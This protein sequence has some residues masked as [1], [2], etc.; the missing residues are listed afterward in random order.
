MLHSLERVRTVIRGGQPDRPPLFEL[1]RN[2]A[3]IRHFTGTELTV[4]NGADLVYRAYAPAVDATRPMVKHPQ[5]EQTLTLADGRRQEIRRWTVWTEHRRFPDSTAYEREMRGR[6]A[7]YAPAWTPADQRALDDAL[8]AMAADRARLGEV[9]CFP[10]IPGPGLMGLYGEVGLEQFAYC[11]ADCPDVAV[12][13][14][15]MNTLAA[16]RWY[17]HLPEGH[18]IEAGFLGDDI[19]FKSG[20]LLNPDWLRAHYFPRLARTIAA[21][22]ARGI[23]VLFHSDGNLNP[24]LDDLVAAGIDGL[25]PIEVLAGM[26]VGTIHRRYPRLFMAGGIDVSQL[27]PFGTPAQVRD[28]VRRAVDAAEGRLMVGSSTELNEEVPLANFLALREAVLAG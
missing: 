3:V 28:A 10:G 20:P 15:E 18:G 12:E 2:S 24:I 26:D 23:V 25:N 13:L 7:A 22:H 16:E 27:L 17:R 14:L 11:L 9:F 19:A 6:L 1:L 4:E 21:A 5:R 8:A